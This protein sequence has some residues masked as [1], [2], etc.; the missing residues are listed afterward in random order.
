MVIHMETIQILSVMRN[1]TNSANAK[2][3]GFGKSEKTSEVRN[4]KRR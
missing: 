1:N 2:F 4:K 3:N